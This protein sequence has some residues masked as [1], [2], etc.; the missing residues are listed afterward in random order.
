MIL[1]A[2]ALPVR[3]E[4]SFLRE[5]DYRI[6]TIGYRIAT[7][8]PALCPRQG[9]VSGLTFHHLSD[10][11]AAD[12]P[13]MIGQGLDRGPGVLTVVE[14]SPADV[15]GLRAGDVLLTV[16]ETPFPSPAT[17]LAGP[18]RRAWRTASDASETLFQ[19]ALARGP[20][21]LRVLRGGQTLSLTLTPRSG[22]LF[23]IR[24]AYSAQQRAVAASPYILVTSSLVELTRNDD[25][26]AF[27]IAHEMAHVALDHATQLK[28]RGIPRNGA[29]RGFGKNGAFVR[30]TEDE[31]DQLGGRLMMAAGY[32][33]PRG[34]MILPRMGA[35]ITF[36]GM[37]QTHAD[38]ADRIRRMREL[39]GVPPA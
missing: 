12:R 24:L 21:A 15:A 10:Y 31:A 25:E 36:F 37:F 32:D 11:E 2:A 26:L 22:C 20:V 29:A 4:G 34:V 38:D 7:A 23:R 19:D 8:A 28:A 27:L 18:D 5:P 13:A 17:I 39:A 3:A 14:G 6:A 9:P 16:D 1:L 30:R 33:L 35:V